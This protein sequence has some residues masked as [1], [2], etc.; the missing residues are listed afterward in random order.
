MTTAK[1][2]IDVAAS[3]IG[4][5]GDHN[6]FNKWYWVDYTKTYTRDPGTA[7]CA[8]FCSYVAM[9]AGL[10]CSYSASAAGFATQFSRI[11]VEQ[12]DSV[13]PG[14]IVIFNWDGR[15]DTGWS[16]HV[17]IVEWS[18][19]GQDGRFGT[20]EGN[21]G[22]EA[23][24]QVLRVTRT[25]WG[26]YFT[27]FYRPKY[28]ST[29]ATSAKSTAPSTK[30][31]KVLYGI[32]VSSNQPEN[33]FNLV[34][35]DFGIVKATGNPQ[36]YSWNYKNP[37]AATQGKQALAKTGCLGF[38]HFTWGKAAKDEAKLFVD[39]V[40]SLGYLGK[41]ML[42]IDYE[43][44]ALSLGRSWVKQLC[45]ETKKLAGYAPVIYASGNVITNQN[46]KSLGYPIWCANYY[47]AYDPIY[48]YDTSGMKI[49]SGCEDA[50]LWQFTSE[51][52]L[53]G[54][55]ERLD[56]NEFRGSKEDWKKYTGEKGSSTPTPAPTPTPT[57]SP[58]PAKK[59]IEEI[60]K[61]VIA[62]KWGNGD[63]RNRKLTN[64]GY[65]YK[66][67]QEKVN[68]IL[69][70]KAAQDV[71]AGKYG[72]GAKRINALRSI[73]LDPD[74]VQQRVNEILSGNSYD[75]DAVAEDVIAGKYGNGQARIDALRRAGYDPDEIQ[76]RVNELLS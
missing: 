28:D 56:M 1:K 49:W 29:T 33:I 23:E 67:V 11:P 15:T 19:I 30:S 42:V 45:D 46:L 74:R 73:G 9:K 68:D 18:T 25:N 12:E 16:D 5:K 75:I 3:Y 64:A 39:Y 40:K 47:K 62:G 10:K 8:C 60:A 26:N 41:A 35:A 48:G 14:D 38:Y 65:S 58:T 52:Y 27:A 13:K 2:M 24:G 72:N 4:T 7:W 69:V 54:Y 37:Y 6:I 17:G 71:I 53:N 55:S 44:E 57:P 61:E 76:E 31:S 32:D 50:I 20:I 21:T 70:E 36:S 43:A 59:S 51:G 66:K 63:D 34:K 22:N